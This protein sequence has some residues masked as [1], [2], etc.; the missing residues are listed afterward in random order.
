VNHARPVDIAQRP[1]YLI[2]TT[3]LVSHRKPGKYFTKVERPSKFIARPIEVAQSLQFYKT[4]YKSTSPV[5]F[6][7]LVN[8]ARPLD[9]I[10]SPQGLIKSTGLINHTRPV[11]ISQRPQDHINKLQGR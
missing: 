5:V 4:I 3:G 11:N 1:Q 10:Q 9:I 6:T 8:L 2:K 7:G